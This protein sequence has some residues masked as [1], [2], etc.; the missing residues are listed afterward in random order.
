MKTK[1]AI[2]VIFGL[3][4]L[5]AACE[6]APEL[7]PCGPG[8]HQEGAFCFP[9]ETEPPC[10]L[11]THEENNVCVANEVAPPPAQIACGE[12][13]HEEDGLCVPDNESIEVCDGKDND[14]DG[15]VD[16]S[17]PNLGAQCVTLKN[18]VPVLGTLKC[19]TPIASHLYCEPVCG[20]IDLC[21]N[22][23]DDNCDGQVDEG[24]D[25]QQL[26]ITTSPDTPDAQQL[27]LGSTGVTLARFKLTANTSEDVLLKELVI[28]HQASSSGYFGS[29]FGS[30]KNPKIYSG[31]TLLASA[32]AF[33]IKNNNWMSEKFNLNLLVKALAD[34]TLT[35][36]ADITAYTDGGTPSTHQIVLVSGTSA[37]PTVGAAVGAKTG[38]PIKIGHN[39]T[40]NCMTLVR[41]KLTLAHAAD[42]PSG[43][44]V[45]S[46]EQVIAK[47]VAT[48]SSNVGNYSVQ[49]DKLT[50]D[51]NSKGTTLSMKNTVR[52]YK[53]S[54]SNNNI[55]MKWAYLPVSISFN[56]NPIPISAGT[57]RTLIVTLDTANAMISPGA[58]LSVGVNGA[59]WNDGVGGYN[60]IDTLPIAGKTLI[61]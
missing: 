15:Q 19:T 38:L 52:I 58:T 20:T 9:N 24:C 8:T 18:G 60:T 30:L 33:S 5:L 37:V 32:P 13:T 26:T 10:G 55:V 36:K 61:Y 14:G 48:N 44:A 47:F 12:G 46:S 25:N 23:I 22:G 43:A 45:P 42:S 31:N 28:S 29:Y 27:V 11:G 1:L 16:E 50:F 54:I 7:P 2:L 49:L 21:N 56:I 4:G 34:A 57:S 6:P 40:G 53:D 3:F 35:V 41:S 39:A 59:T 17:D 51:F